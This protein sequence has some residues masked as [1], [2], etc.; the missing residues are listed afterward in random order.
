MEG[1]SQPPRPEPRGATHKACP[2]MAKTA[3]TGRVDAPCNGHHCAVPGMNKPAGFM[4]RFARPASAG[5]DRD[6]GRRLP[7]QVV[8]RRDEGVRQEAVHLLHRCDP[9]RPQ[10]GRN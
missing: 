10:H 8:V 4:A 9:G 7:E 3:P 6:R 1:A 5:R 2:N